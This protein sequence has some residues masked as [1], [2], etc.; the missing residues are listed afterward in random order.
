MNQRDFM[1][2]A[3]ETLSHIDSDEKTER[4]VF[5]A[6][7]LLEQALAA[8]PAPLVRLN[9]DAL[10]N[11]YLECKA[12]WKATNRRQRQR[13]AVVFG[14]ALMDAMERVNQ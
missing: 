14:N 11:I 1:R 2:E 5:R 12:E 8:E 10:V 13:I 6:E 3:L 7:T 9:D 4:F